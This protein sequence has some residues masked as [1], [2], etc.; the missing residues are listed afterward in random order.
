MNYVISLLVL[1]S[2]PA[3]ADLHIADWK[4]TGVIKEKDVV[5]LAKAALDKDLGSQEDGKT[6]GVRSIDNLDKD[7]NAKADAAQFTVSGFV[8][9]PYVGCSGSRVYHCRLAYNTTADQKL[10]LA[11]T[12]CDPATNGSED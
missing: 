8:T 11:S 10:Q 3:F 2:A 4:D 9:A 12:E 7:K 5:G 6:C 1:I